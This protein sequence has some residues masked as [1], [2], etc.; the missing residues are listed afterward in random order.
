[1]VARAASSVG[2]G[3]GV[4][5]LAIFAFV[6]LQSAFPQQSRK[7]RCQFIRSELVSKLL[8]DVRLN[9]ANGPR[10]REIPSRDQVGQH[11]LWAGA[12]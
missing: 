2:S 8:V 11:L 12:T 4:L 9:L 10:P 7:A 3:V 5:I 6:A 1:M